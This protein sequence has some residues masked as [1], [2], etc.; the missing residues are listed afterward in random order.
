M[1]RTKPKPATAAS[2][3]LADNARADRR[4]R[5]LDQ[6]VTDESG[7]TRPTVAN[8]DLT[9]SG[10]HSGGKN[11]IQAS[12][13]A[14]YAM[15]L[16]LPL[17]WVLG[18]DV[19]IWPLL[20]L[21]LAWKLV[22]N[23]R[24]V[25]VPQGFHLWSLFLIWLALSAL[26]LSDASPTR[27]L[28]FAWRASLYFSATVV[29]LYFYNASSTTLIRST[30][31]AATGYWMLIALGGYAGVIFPTASYESPMAHLVPAWLS[32]NKFVHD[33]VVYRGLAGI[34]PFSL[35]RPHAGF[36]YANPWGSTF[37]LLI[38]LVAA[39]YAHLSSA[40]MKA[41]I[42]AL[43]GLAAVPLT[44][45]LNRGAWLSIGI[46]LLYAAALGLWRKQPKL[47]WSAIVPGL[48]IG[49]MV[50]LTPLKDVAAQNLQYKVD[51][52]S[53]RLNLYREAFVG[54][55]ES[56]LFG[57][58]TPRPSPIADEPSIGTHGQVWL[59]LFSQGFPGLFFFLGWLAF[60]LISSR[61]ACSV[62][63]AWC[64]VVVLMGAAQAFY[65]ELAGTGLVIIFMAGALALS[66]PFRATA[67]GPYLSEKQA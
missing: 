41:V 37:A 32:E 28:A 34:D 59:V 62:T 29:F 45:S 36:A 46:G 9:S 65:Y 7:G 55:L 47:F 44:F 67:R 56:P 40:W 12:P 52:N 18:M 11:P 51:S 1:T 58:G 21:P 5:N 13:W 10:V 53:T 17:W 15:L 20:V 23:R 43:L 4:G 48:M 25:N 57:H 2:G 63:G 3:T 19:F 39:G 38:P 8:P 64:H 6:T 49:G 14:P 22:V 30:L 54:A 26:T 50:A 31:L 42:A 27:Q 24:D 16:S 35:P 60:L 66:D 33:A 61:K